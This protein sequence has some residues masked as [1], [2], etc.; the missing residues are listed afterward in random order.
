MS[1]EQKRELIFS[2]HLKREEKKLKR[3]RRRIISVIALI[4]IL[5]IAS[6]MIFTVSAKE[7]NIT[8]IDEFNGKNVTKTVYVMSGSVGEVLDKQELDIGET[9]KISISVHTEIKNDEEIVIKRGKEIT[10][11]ADGVSEEVIVTKADAH[12][13][14]VEAGYVPSENDEI[15]VLGGSDLKDGDGIELVTVSESTD[16]INEKIENEVEYRNDPTM[17]E[18][19]TRVIEE[20]QSGLR[21][22]TSNVIYRSGEEASRTVVSDNITVEPKKKII[23]V[24]TKKTPSP[25]S[26]SG[27]EVNGLKYSKKIKM[28]ATAYSTSPSENG[29]YTVSALG[30][31]L[32]HGVVAVDPSVI[33]LGT[34]LYITSVDGSWTYGYARAEDTGGAIK[35]NKIDLCFEGTP[36]EVNKFGRRN[37][38]VYI[39]D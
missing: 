20:G 7:I 39:L 3:R 4:L 19:E 2:L 28:N 16:I 26:A 29:G 11:V 37:C 13:A 6:G 5:A 12:D 23:A 27:G 15:T 14:L 32:G 36:Q 30:T 38:I 34:R 1:A 10:I 22:I 18:G 25:T 33:P 9:D 8:E 24:G 31:K 17:P 35:G 21:E